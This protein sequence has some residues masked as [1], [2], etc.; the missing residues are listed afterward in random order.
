MT[1][2]IELKN[3]EWKYENTQE[4]ALKGVNLSIEEHK[5]L[6][7]VG[8]NE[9]G[10]TTLVSAISGLVPHSFNGIYRGDVLLFG[11]PVRQ[12][13]SLE[14]ATKVGLVFSDPE[15]QFTA[16][17]VEEE[18]AF[19]LENI[20][21]SLQEIKERLDW[22]AK[23]TMIEELLDKSPYDISGGQKQRVAIA[24][25]LAMN[26]PIIIMDEPTSMID[27]LGKR[28]IFDILRKLK[29]DGKHTL[30]VVEHNVEQLAQLADEMILMSNGQIARHETTLEFFKDPAYLIEQGISPPECTAYSQW[31]KDEGYLPK[32]V[33]LPLT[34]EGAVE[35]A[36]PIF[37]RNA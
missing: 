25:V 8:A 35:L 24:C 11:K 6:G 3:L 19:G 17:T 20:G 5:F 32:N 21:Y 15:A 10:K 37:E 2:I 29:D 27:P 9:Q 33:T 31:L 13:D 34:L 22:A 36:R 12:M 26:P 18:L 14:L 4:F 1:S 16:M 23:I 30:I 28:L 7:V